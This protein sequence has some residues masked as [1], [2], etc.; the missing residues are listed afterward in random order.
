MHLYSPCHL[1]SPL[2][3]VGQNGKAKAPARPIRGRRSAAVIPHPLSIYLTWGRAAPHLACCC[4]ISPK[5]SLHTEWTWTPGW[6]VLTVWLS[7][8]LCFLR[9]TA[10]CLSREKWCFALL[11]D[12]TPCILAD[13][14]ATLLGTLVEPQHESIACQWLWALRNV[15]SFFFFNHQ[16][17]SSVLTA[18]GPHKLAAGSPC[19]FQKILK[20]RLQTAWPRVFFFFFFS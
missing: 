15:E 10:E 4:V 17:L 5:R 12:C 18:A 14:L 7:E 19:S 11:E 6:S 3:V 9:A 8:A 16:E 20:L 1:T 13:F 2:E